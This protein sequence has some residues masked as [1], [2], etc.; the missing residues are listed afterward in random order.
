EI[1]LLCPTYMAEWIVVALV[2]IFR[3][4]AAGPVGTGD[5]EAQLLLVEIRPRKFE[6]GHADKD[7]TPALAAHQGRLMHGFAAWRRGGQ[8]HGIH[9]APAREGKGGRHRICSCG[10]VDR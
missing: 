3:V 5:L 4:I 9:A 2:F 6:T 8:D 10:K 1:S 7:D